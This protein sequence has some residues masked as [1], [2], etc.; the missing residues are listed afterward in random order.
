MIVPERVE[1]STHE[2]AVREHVPEIK[3]VNIIQ[4]GLSL[5]AALHAGRL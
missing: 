1:R 4:L 5:L 3:H 2:G